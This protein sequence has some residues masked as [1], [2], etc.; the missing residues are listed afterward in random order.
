MTLEIKDYFG[1]PVSLTPRVGLYEV[2][3]FM[4][5]EMP[6][7]AILLDETESG[8]PYA[9]LTV[10]FGEF[11]SVK[12]SAYI[13]TNNCRF[14]DQLLDLGIAEPTSFT[15]QSGF[16]TYPLWVFKEDFLK[17]VGG[18]KYQ[19]YSQAYDDYFDSISESEDEIEYDEMSL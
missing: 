3:D 14:A 10:S 19:E 2:Y 17:E 15:K 13:D 16:C 9:V 4:G 1:K 11:I 5:N 18:E 6:G 8:E 12:N 7:L